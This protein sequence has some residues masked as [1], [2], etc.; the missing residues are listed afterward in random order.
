MWSGLP[1]AAVGLWDSSRG[2]LKNGRIYLES[3]VSH[4]SVS[5]LFAITEL[6]AALYHTQLSIIT[7]P[8]HDRHWHCNNEGLDGYTSK[9]HT[10]MALSQQSSADG[11]RIFIDR[12]LFPYK[13][14]CSSYIENSKHSI[15]MK[16]IWK[17]FSKQVDW[18]GGGGHKFLSEG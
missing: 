14:R 9:A 11:S 18:H 17:F 8:R 6:S 12:A 2:L 10:V 16:E 13:V 5:C 7:S 15:V 3:K 1:C 4:Q